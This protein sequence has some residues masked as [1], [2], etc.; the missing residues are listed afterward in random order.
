MEL[1]LDGRISCFRVDGTLPSARRKVWRSLE[2][3][4][5]LSRFVPQVVAVDPQVGNPPQ[6]YSFSETVM[7]E[8]VE[9]VPADWEWLSLKQGTETNLGGALGSPAENERRGNYIAVSNTYGYTI[10]VVPKGSISSIFLFRFS[11]PTYEV[12]FG[13]STCKFS[14]KVLPFCRFGT[15]LR[16]FTSLEARFFFPFFTPNLRWI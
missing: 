2:R 14:T 1:K 6:T 5:N 11:F 8:S 13:P 10:V 12:L 9:A 7:T 4:R 3:A 16:H 15:L